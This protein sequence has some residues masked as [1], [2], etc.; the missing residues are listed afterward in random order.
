LGEVQVFEDASTIPI[1][2]A[3]TLAP[4]LGSVTGFNMASVAATVANGFE[5]GKSYTLVL[6]AGTVDSVSVVGEVVGRFRIAAAAR[7]YPDRTIYFD[8]DAGNTNAVYGVDGTSGNPVSDWAAV[9]ALIAASGFATVVANGALSLSATPGALAIIAEEGATVDLNGQDISSTR[10]VG[11]SAV[12]STI[13]ASGSGASFVSCA[14]AAVNTIPEGSSLSD[15]VIG[16]VT[17]TM[18]AA[19]DF[20]FTDCRFK[21]TTLAGNSIASGTTRMTGCSGRLTVSGYGAHDILCDNC[22]GDMTVAGSQS[23]L[24]VIVY[25]GIF[26]FTNTGLA[27]ITQTHENASQGDM[28][29]LAAG[30]ITGTTQAGTLSATQAPTSLTGYADNQLIGRVIIFTSGVCDGEA[31]DITDY[32]SIDGT[33]TFTALTTQPGVGDTFKIV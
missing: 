32:A 1:T 24:D 6:A 15:C 28:D 7:A 26:S 9:A 16:A 3:E 23:A 22:F 33:L 27:N 10:F 13:A 14:I 2:A 19:G 17:L 30:I 5:T 25:G 4:S 29:S 20:D 12:T 31:T 11:F 8:I 18:E 21:G